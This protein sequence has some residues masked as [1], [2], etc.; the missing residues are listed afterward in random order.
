MTR[1]GAWFTARLLD[2][3]SERFTAA[4]FLA[5]GYFPLAPFDHT[6]INAQ[7]KELLGYELYGYHLF[8]AEEGTD[9]IMESHVRDARSRIQTHLLTSCSLTLSFLWSSLTTQRYGRPMLRP[10]ELRRR[11]CWRTSSPSMLRI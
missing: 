9:K 8:F 3:Y 2:F 6:T 4:A 5:V 1:R 10:S 7:T 11:H